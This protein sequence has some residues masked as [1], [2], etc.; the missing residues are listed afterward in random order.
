MDGSTYVKSKMRSLKSNRRKKSK[1]IKKVSNILQNKK[2][3]VE[4]L[5]LLFFSSTSLFL[6]FTFSNQAWRPISF[7][8]TKITGLSGISKHDIQ[9]ITGNF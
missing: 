6:I 1:S 3:L 4:L 2:F 5:Q 9:K 7:E 8:E